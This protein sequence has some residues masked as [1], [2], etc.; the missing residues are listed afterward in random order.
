MIELKQGTFGDRV[1]AVWSWW[2]EI[3]QIG[4]FFL[5]FAL[6]VAIAGVIAV[7][8]HCDDWRATRLAERSAKKWHLDQ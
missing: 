7:V 5:L 2:Y 6:A 8:V 3:P 1:T 4:R